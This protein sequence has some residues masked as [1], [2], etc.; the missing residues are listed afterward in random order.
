MELNKHIIQQGI[1]T[2]GSEVLI[3]FLAN[4]KFSYFYPACI[5]TKP[6]AEI[7]ILTSN[8]NENHIIYINFI[9]KHPSG[10]IC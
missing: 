9:F 8:K 6:L 2:S 7:L 5:N 3:E 10:T 4:R 1:Y